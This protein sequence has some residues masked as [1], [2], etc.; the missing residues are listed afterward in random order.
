MGLGGMNGTDEVGWDGC[1]DQVG[2]RT[3]GCKPLGMG[4]R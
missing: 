3:G 1:S 4:R 2:G